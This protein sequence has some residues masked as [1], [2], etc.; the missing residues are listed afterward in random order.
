MTKLQSVLWHRVRSSQPLFIY[1]IQ[2]GHNHPTSVLSSGAQHTL[3]SRTWR[4]LVSFSKATSAILTTHPLSN[5]VRAHS[6]DP[7]ERYGTIW[8]LVRTLTDGDLAVINFIG[9]FNMIMHAETQNRNAVG[10]YFAIS[11][12]F[13]LC[14]GIATVINAGIG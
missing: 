1:N 14:F 7:E 10:C 11:F 6:C 2:D 9:T 5:I 3:K 8:L 13:S 12:V 4:S